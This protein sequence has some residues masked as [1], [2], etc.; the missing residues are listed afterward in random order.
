MEARSNSR[1]S[2]IACPGEALKTAPLGLGAIESVLAPPWERNTE[3]G[4]R[5]TFLYSV[6]TVKQESSL[7]LYKNSCVLKHIS[8]VESY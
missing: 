4:H 8:H 1:G 5:T 2:P 3:A 6:V 7:A